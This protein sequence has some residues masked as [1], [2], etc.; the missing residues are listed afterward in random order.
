MHM[1]HLIYMRFG[2]S[3]IAVVRTAIYTYISRY[4]FGWRPHVELLLP[5]DVGG[6]HYRPNCCSV[7]EVS[8]EL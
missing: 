4:T 6:F 7:T 2:I 3:V 8:R 5:R 1:S